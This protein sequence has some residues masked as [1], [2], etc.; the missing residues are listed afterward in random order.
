MDISKVIGT[1][2]LQQAQE[3]KLQ[4]KKE[5]TAMEFERMFARHLVQEM[6]KGSFTMSD[7]AIG[8]SSF[9]MYREHINETLAN[10]LASQ[11]KLGMSDLVMKHWKL[12]TE[13]S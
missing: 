11:K 13:E 6:T 7:N 3:D 2:S 12:T 1:L 8:A 5:E 9:T 10:E 4:Q